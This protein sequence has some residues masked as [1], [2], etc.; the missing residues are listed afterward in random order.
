M[1]NKFR[2]K[3]KEPLVKD[4]AAI[5][6]SPTPAPQNSGNGPAEGKLPETSVS[7]QQQQQH[8]AEQPEEL[9]A[10]I[11]AVVV[12]DSDRVDLCILFVWILC[13]LFWTVP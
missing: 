8:V 12:S 3:R 6:S 13:I 9:E 5:V 1:I 4:S 2:Y 10:C 11:R 7:Q